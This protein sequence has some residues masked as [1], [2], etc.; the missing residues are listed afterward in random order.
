[1]SKAVAKKSKIIPVSVYDSSDTWDILEEHAGAGFE[2]TNADDFVLPFIKKAEHQS[3]CL[4]KQHEK[5]VPGAEAGQLVHNVM[6]K[7][8]DTL[9]ML[10]VK[11]DNFLQ[12]YKFPDGTGGWLGN[13]KFNAPDVPEYPKVTKDDRTYRVPIAM[14]DSYLQQCFNYIG[15]FFDKDMTP[16]GPAILPMEK[17]QCRTAR[18]FNVLLNSKKITLANG[19]SIKAPIFSHLYEIS[20]KPI[21]NDKGSFY[22]FAYDTGTVVSDRA[23]LTDAVDLMKSLREVDTTT[24]APEV[25]GSDNTEPSN[26][27]FEI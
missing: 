7:S 8:F 5:Y 21:T 11:Y 26:D 15:L 3:K 25:E 14:P 20:L 18:M 22:A 19:N 27:S 2:D 16:I 13:Y 10:P 12:H 9:Y 24:L 17:S 4:Q 23:M 1:M 6:L